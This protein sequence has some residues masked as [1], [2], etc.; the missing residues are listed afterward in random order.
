MVGAYQRSPCISPQYATHVG[1]TSR[2]VQ[3][4]QTGNTTKSASNFVECKVS[5]LTHAAEEKVDTSVRIDFR[6]V[7]LTFIFRA[8]GITVKKVDVL[9][10]DID[11]QSDTSASHM[12]IRFVLGFTMI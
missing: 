9:G 6:L 11:W 8:C 1:A 10:W 4:N 2:L 12:C 5:I 7:C 3:V